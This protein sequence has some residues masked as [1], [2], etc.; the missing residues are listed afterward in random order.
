ME[1]G[2]RQ[3]L[4]YLRNLFEERGV[5]PKNKLGQ[6]FLIDLNLLDL[7]LRAAE[8]TRDDLVLE[9]GSGTGNLTVRLLERAGAVVSV[10]IDSSFAAL[11]DEAVRVH[12]DRVALMHADVLKSK[13]ELN[14]DV[15]RVVADMKRR[16]GCTQVKVTAN[17]PYAVAVPVIS[18]ALL[19]DLDVERFVVTVQ[20]EIAERLLAVPG[21][22][23]YG[24]VA[25][26]VQSLTEVSLIRRLPSSVFWPRPKVDSA[27]MLIRPD[28]EKRAQVGDVMRFRRFLRD[29]YVH[30]RKNLR[31]ALAALP[32]RP[33][34]KTEVDRKL[35]QLG[36]EGTLRAEML[37]IDQHL[38]LCKSFG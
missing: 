36:I 6:N 20:W 8:L 18:N 3:T 21:S 9:V 34:E 13:N 1:T 4:S 30:R 31:G 22:K 29:L 33:Y 35:A 12:R 23:A 5:R 37:N 26:L 17:L 24:A 14:P 2:A 28:A 19:S 38:E 7:L 15:L 32:S 16:H 25:V 11:T 10:E 27:I